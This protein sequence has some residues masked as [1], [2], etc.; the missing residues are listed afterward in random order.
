M[1]RCLCCDA[2]VNDTMVMAWGTDGTPAGYDVD[3]EPG[4]ATICLYCGYLQMFADDGTLCHPTDEELL[5]LLPSEAIGRARAIRALY[6]GR[7]Q[8]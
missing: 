3:P 4:D 6:V 7:P 5:E 1:R 2:N 8:P